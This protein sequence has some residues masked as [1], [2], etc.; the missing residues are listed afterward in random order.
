MTVYLNPY[1]HLEG[2]HLETYDVENRFGRL[3]RPPP[4]H[5]HSYFPRIFPYFAQTRR[6]GVWREAVWVFLKFIKRHFAPL[7]REP[8]LAANEEN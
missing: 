1:R 2:F 4:H 6:F 7:A 8:A 5:P 3:S